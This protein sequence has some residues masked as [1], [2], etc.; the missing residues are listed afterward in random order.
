M[1]PGGGISLAVKHRA[2]AYYQHQVPKQLAM[3]DYLFIS[4]RQYTLALE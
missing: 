4:C 3:A 1:T 2:L